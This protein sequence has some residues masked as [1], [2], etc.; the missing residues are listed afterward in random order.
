MPALKIFFSY[1]GGKWRAAPHYP[2]PTEPHIIEPFAG[3]AGYAMRYPERKVTLIDA[4][5]RFGPPR[6][7]VEQEV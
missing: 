1:F 6:R 3:A 5:P 7:L 2:A 4:D